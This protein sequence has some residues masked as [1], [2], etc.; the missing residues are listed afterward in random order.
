M[1]VADASGLPIAVSIA[2]GPRHETRLV[3]ETLEARFVRRLPKRL[4]GDKAYDSAILEAQLA[5]H[6]IELVCPV[7]EGIPGVRRQSKTRRQDRRSLRRYKKRWKIE[8]LFAWLLRF[9]RLVNRWEP[10]AENFLGFL[11]LGCIKILLRRL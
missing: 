4:I 10:K 6:R 8:R 5:K 1:A 2:D 3:E 7:R 11:Q 9:R